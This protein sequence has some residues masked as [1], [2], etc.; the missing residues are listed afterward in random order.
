MFTSPYLTSEV[1]KRIQFCRA[2]TLTMENIDFSVF[3]R[4]TGEHH[5]LAVDTDFPEHDCLEWKHIIW[6]EECGSCYP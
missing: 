3:A 1:G 6:K 5:S 4:E 2:R